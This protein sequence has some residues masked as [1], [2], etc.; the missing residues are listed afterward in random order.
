MNFA[1][2]LFV[3]ALLCA[4]CAFLAG[5]N[6]ARNNSGMSPYLV[7]MAD[8]DKWVWQ[9]TS[10]NNQLVAES[11]QEFATVEDAIANYD[12]VR[13]AVKATAAP[14]IIVNHKL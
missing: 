4:A 5:C 14:A 9:I 8:S 2:G 6:T 1:L 10:A 12:L 7:R 11:E 13:A 3:G